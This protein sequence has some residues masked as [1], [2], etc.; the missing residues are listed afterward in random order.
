[1]SCWHMQLPTFKN[2]CIL[3]AQFNIHLTPWLRV[4]FRWSCCCWKNF[5]ADS[6][7]LKYS[8]AT[9]E[10]Q[11]PSSPGTGRSHFP[12]TVLHCRGPHISISAR[13][14][15]WA[16]ASQMACTCMTNLM[17]SG[18]TVHMQQPFVLDFWVSGSPVQLLPQ[19]ACL[20]SGNP[21]THSQTLFPLF[22]TS[23]PPALT[24]SLPTLFWLAL[25]R[26]CFEGVS[27]SI[28]KHEEPVVL[29]CRGARQG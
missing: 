29:A 1:M 21:L 12:V 3:W 5:N 28:P 11:S 14:D 27:S 7:V 22:P 9:T 23:P 25:R 6:L 13:W 15:Y 2:R 26:G 24:P 20:P 18:R 10:G 4:I 19:L 16:F 17:Y 8:I